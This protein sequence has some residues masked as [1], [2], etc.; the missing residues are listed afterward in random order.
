MGR[1]RRLHIPNAIVHIT[2]KCHDSAM[3]LLD[4]ADK[5]L[6]LAILDET[7]REMDYGVVS[8]CL[9]DNHLHHILETPPDIEG[10]TLS[11]FMFRVLN[12]FSHRFNQRHWRTGTVWN[13]RFRDTAWMSRNQLLALEIL[14]WYVEANT[15]RRR[16]RPVPPWEWPWCSAYRLFHGRT[17][18]PATRLQDYVNRLYRA[19]GD[20]LDEFRKLLS[21]QRPDWSKRARQSRFINLDRRTELAVQHDLKHL[22]ESIQTANQRSWKLEVARYSMLAQPILHLV[23]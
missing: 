2:L 3:L 11:E 5:E 17:D 16:V 15:W 13:G 20:P 10:H 8:F 12:R 4:E 23:V 18:Q 21:L 7:A 22:N 9:Q 6:Y 14:L 19:R 1:R